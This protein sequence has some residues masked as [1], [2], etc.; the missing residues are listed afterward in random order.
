MPVKV[1]FNISR[2][3]T[4]PIHRNASCFELSKF[5]YKRFDFSLSLRREHVVQ[6]I[7]ACATSIVT[8]LLR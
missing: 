2:S 6:G 8:T 7:E 5:V 1:G 4:I 3:I